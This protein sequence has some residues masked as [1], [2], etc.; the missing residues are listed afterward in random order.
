MTDVARNRSRDAAEEI[1][2][3][4]RAKG[5]TVKVIRQDP[6]GVRWTVSTVEDVPRTPKYTT[7][8]PDLTPEEAEKVHEL[9]EARKYAETPEEKAALQAAIESASFRPKEPPPVDVTI[10]RSAT[11]EITGVSVPG[12]IQ[13]A[14]V[15]GG[16]V[17]FPVVEARKEWEETGLVPGYVSKQLVLPPGFAE[18]GI[19][20]KQWESMAYRTHLGYFTDQ[21]YQDWFRGRAK[22]EYGR[23]G[24]IPSFIDV[25]IPKSVSAAG[26]GEEYR[27]LSYELS[28]GVKSEEEITEEWQD[29]MSGKVSAMPD[30]DKPGGE[31]WWYKKYGGEEGT[32]VKLKPDEKIEIRDG[33]AVIVPVTISKPKERSVWD[34][35]DWTEDFVGTLSAG[36]SDIFSLERPQYVY[37]SLSRPIDKDYW[38]PETQEMRAIR[39]YGR[40][41]WRRI[42]KE[43]DILGGAARIIGSPLV[44]PP[45]SFGVGAGLA[46]GF[47]LVGMS[48]APGAALFASKG[49]WVTGAVIS[50][51]VGADIGLTA[52]KEEQK[53]VPPGT[54][55][56]KIVIYGAAF[57]SAY[58]GAI[59]V[60]GYTPTKAVGRDP[61][62]NVYLRQYLTTFRGKPV[63]PVSK[64]VI[65][66]RTPT[67]GIARVVSP[68]PSRGGIRYV[69]AESFLKGTYQYG[70]PPSWEPDLGYRGDLPLSI[71]DIK[72]IGKPT[73][74][75]AQWGHKIFYGTG[76]EWQPYSKPVFPISTK[77]LPKPKLY[78]SYEVYYR[79]LTYVPEPVVKLGDKLIDIKPF[80]P[81]HKKLKDLAPSDKQLD[82]LFRGGTEQGGGL[83]TV[84]I[85]K[86][87]TVTVPRVL[88]KSIP[89]MIV[90]PKLTTKQKLQP[91]SKLTQEY[92]TKTV[93]RQRL[94]YGLLYDQRVM[95]R[96]KI[97]TKQMKGVLS[98]VKSKL[99]FDSLK[100][101]RY[102]QIQLQSPAILSAQRKVFDL[103][104]VFVHPQ[105]FYP[106]VIPPRIDIVKPIPPELPPKPGKPR[107]PRFPRLPK[108][109]KS[110][111]VYMKTEEEP[112][113]GYNVM[114][115]SRQYYKGKPK[116]TEKY[117]KLTSKS[118]SH[119]DAKSLLGSALDHSIAQTGY[120]KP[121]GKP[122]KKLHKHI[123]SRWESI[124]FKFNKKNGKWQEQRAYA[125]DTRGES[126]ELN[127]FR[128]YQRLPS[129]KKQ[130]RGGII[131]YPTPSVDM[132]SFD[133]LTD[134][135]NRM[136]RRRRF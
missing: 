106:R 55:I 70:K 8:A 129:K 64:P 34:I 52:A 53:L 79:F 81:V 44:L 1:A 59:S 63:I 42:W 74:Q 17:V 76:A 57:Y 25:D 80:K 40:E 122:A 78:R 119:N 124:S 32:G 92:K 133:K 33:Q 105:I 43:R 4:Y 7:P 5:Y 71:Y 123:P 19:T 26:A 24:I 50:G 112:D 102:A 77:V 27:R 131:E 107:Y 31:I 91:F 116:G 101:I 35:G 94:A 115:K 126:D 3:E 22:G 136:L 117:R 62:G 97:D 67:G 90:K 28:V 9:F 10:E 36:V 68:F 14:H 72:P 86:T 83:K 84:Q 121:S 99:G 130:P 109:P 69:T 118:F 47:R 135:F 30:V 100:K 23:T 51:T 134:N 38:K 29:I 45:V 58:L 103:K 87:K 15:M 11:G 128:W 93:S 18:V 20:E 66:G 13:P 127:V 48:K 110:R 114:V 98:G 21:Q 46:T 104:H 111:M 85:T 54:T 56:G 39:E 73:G 65:L 96:Q 12:Y 125:I 89:K 60:A 113:Q 95:Q 37:A 88:Q 75:V 6:R 41:E 2:K 120:I 82:R 16:R 108:L 61:Y 49:P 132:Y